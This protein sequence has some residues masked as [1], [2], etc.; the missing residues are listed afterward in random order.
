MFDRR[1]G[2]GVPATGR[3][4]LDAR[5]SRPASRCYDASA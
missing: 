1:I 5:L 4:L 2:D 3:L